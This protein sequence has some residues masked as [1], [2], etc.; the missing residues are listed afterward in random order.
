MPERPEPAL[1]IGQ[2]AP[3]DPDDVCRLER[4][5]D[6]DLRP[7]Q[8]RRVDLE[9]RVLG[10]RADQDDVA[11]LDARQEGVLLRL[12]E[13]VDLVDEEDGAAAEPAPRFLRFGHHRADFLDAGQHGAER[14]EV[15]AGRAGDQPRQRGLAGARRTPEDHRLQAV[16]LDGLPQRPAGPDERV[17]ADEFVERPRPHALGQ[18]RQR[19][20]SVRRLPPG[21]RRRRATRHDVRWPR[22]LPLRFV[23]DQRRGRRDVERLDGGRIGNGEPVVGQPSEIGGRA[24]ALAAEQRPRRAGEDRSAA[25][26]CRRAAPRQGAAI[27][28]SPRALDAPSRRLRRG[29]RQAERAAHRSAQ[30][31]PAERI[32]GAV[33]RRRP[34]LRRRH[35][36][37]GDGADVPGVLH[38]VQHQHQLRRVAERLVERRSRRRAIATI[39]DGAGPGSLLRGRTVHAEQARARRRRPPRERGDLTV[40]RRASTATTSTGRCASSASATRCGPSRR[41]SSPPASPASRNRLTTGFWRLVMAGSWAT[42]LVEQAGLMVALSAFCWRRGPT[43]RTPA[44]PHPRASSA[45]FARAGG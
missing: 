17:L 10:R 20:R 32:G 4:L 13:A 33:A 41:S 42:Y 27:R 3:Q 18:R 15:R 2:R 28:S 9:R 16:L 19:R 24:R 37:P 40:R 39:P 35:P 26:A 6:V 14:D 12:V 11:G 30:R 5:E 29:D 44:G 25:A 21:V 1:R 38:L 31:F 36:R 45:R 23:G 22:A 43:P 7:R 8:Q 34:R